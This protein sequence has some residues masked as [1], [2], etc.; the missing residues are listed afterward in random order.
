MN[1]ARYR[2]GVD[3]G[4]T[5]TDATLLDEASGALR[6]AKV[7]TTPADPSSG[8][9]EAVRRILG[10]AGV[11]PGQVGRVV[12]A[13]TV[14]TNAIIEGKVA[15]T[16][17][18]T[19]EGFRDLLEIQRQVRPSLYD[20]QFEKPRPLVPRDRCF[21]LPERLDARGAVLIPLDEA[22][23]AA[24]ADRLRAEGVEAVAICLLHA[25]ANPAH[26]RRVAEIVR[27]RFPEASVSVSSEV[28]PE[29][30]EYTR[31]STTVVNAAIQPVVARYLASIEA[32]LR[33][34]GLD[35]ELL[36]MQ[37]NGGVF[38]F[39]GARERP[40]FM[41]ESGPA[42]GVIAAAY[43]GGQIER[44]NVISFDMGGT[45]A[46]A[47]LVQGGAPRVTK[48]YELGATARAGLGSGR[49][50]GYPIRTPVIDLVEIGAGGG[51]IAWID[52]GGALRVGPRSAGADPGPACYGRGGAEPTVTDA[53]LLLGRLS[54]DYFLGGELPLDVELA[55][56]AIE[57][58]CAARLG[59]GVVETAHA[60]V[61]I[62]N[63]AM[64]GAIRLVSVQRGYDPREH[65]LVAFGGAGPAHACRL[66]AEVEVPTTVVPV[67]PGIFS[68][69]GLLVTDL[70]HEY[71]AT[72]IASLDRLDA[73]EVE[74]VFGGLE[75]EGRA[76]LERDGVAAEAIA[77]ERQA[78]LRYV[79]QS[80]ELTVP[81]GEEMLA[82]FHGEHD[83]AYGYAAPSEPV[84]LVNLRLTALGRIP[85]PALREVA[86]GGDPAAARK[87]G[88]AV[89]F[90]EAGGFVECPV[91]DRARLPAGAV[92]A[93]PA[94]VEELDSTTV[95][96]PGY[97]AR[98]DRYGNLL[99][100]K[101]R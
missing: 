42:A 101:A 51:S 67:S 61:E 80:Y 53:N 4:G 75:A 97:E 3:I 55:R 18:I 43:L 5:F 64:A 94:A 93:G 39:A 22:A 29:F 21:G 12:H 52:S 40:V 33:A 49:G 70:K 36:V 68:A 11:A 89:Y 86:A 62:A 88:R 24:A 14:A 87:G 71:A 98:V 20:L 74:R 59:L 65:V 46:K 1:P 73:A 48:E 30:R 10:E 50:S 19:T 16:G 44:P 72:T 100:E 81:F 25:Y 7:S 47:G 78:D 91:Y 8:F 34:E 63:A 79:G 35:A 58:R 76:A 95:V 27:A 2:L 56:R 96:H 54:A 41:V 38:P 82:R 17:F 31:A 83:R 85:K 69:L 28:A 99:L 84:E 37:S 66:A 77:F 15:A 6:I 23:A 90:A 60:I 9:M 57:A 13:T 92:L 45:T 26:E 32:R